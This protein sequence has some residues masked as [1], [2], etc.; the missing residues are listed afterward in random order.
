[1]HVKIFKHITI[2]S[3]LYITILRL[4]FGKDSNTTTKKTLNESEK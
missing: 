2:A 1:M 3:E 4:K